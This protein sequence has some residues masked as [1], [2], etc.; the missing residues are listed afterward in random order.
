[1]PIQIDPPK[2]GN[3]NPLYDVQFVNDPVFAFKVIRRSSGEVLFDTSL[4]GFTYADQFLQLTT[5]LPSTNL[6]G[7]GENEQGTFKHHFDKF[8]VWPLFSRDQ[9][10]SVRPKDIY[11]SHR[12]LA[13]ARILMEPPGHFI[14]SG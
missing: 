4:G 10:P 5:K 7:I 8:P 9:P 6:F 1:M 3:D 14:F 13:K 2:G 12:F 11:L